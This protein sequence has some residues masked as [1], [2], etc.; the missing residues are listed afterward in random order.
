MYIYDY[1]SKARRYRNGLI[2]LRNKTTRNPK[3]YIRFK[4]PQHNT[5]IKQKEI[6]KPQKERNK[7]DTES[8]GKQGLKWHKYISVNN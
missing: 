2:Y 5:T 6:I 4:K 7:E 3:T 8:I 1:Q